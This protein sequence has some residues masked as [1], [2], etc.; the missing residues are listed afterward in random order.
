MCFVQ[1]GGPYPSSLTSTCRGTGNWAREMVDTS[2]SS[3]YTLPGRVFAARD[4]GAHACHRSPLR[5][6][7]GR[8]RVRGHGRR[9]QLLFSFHALEDIQ[10]MAERRRG[11]IAGVAWISRCAAC[12]VWKARELHVADGGWDSGTLFRRACAAVRTLAQHH[13]HSAPR[14]RHK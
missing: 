3:A 8:N 12:S 14:S 2:R 5:S 10:C 9:G 4:C 7:C 1:E 13:F 6:R 11:V